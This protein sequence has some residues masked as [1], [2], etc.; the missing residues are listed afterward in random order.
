MRLDHYWMQQAVLQVGGQIKRSDGISVMLVGQGRISFPY[1]LPSDGPGIG[2]FQC[3]SPRYT[4]EIHH[5]EVMYTAGDPEAPIV[6]IGAGLFPFKYNPD[7]RDFGDYLLRI[8]PYPQLLQ[9]HFDSPYLR[10]LGLHVSSDFFPLLPEDVLTLHQD[11]LLSSE[12]NL[13]PLKDFSLA[14]LFATTIFKF[15]DVGAGIMGDRMFSVDDILDKPTAANN[16]NRFTFGGLKIMLRL[17]LDFK[18]FLPSKDLWGTNDWRF[19]S[20]ACLNG[21]KD[22]PITDTNNA[23]YPGY[24]DR[25]KRIPVLL[26]CNVPTCGLL[27]VLSIEGEWWGNNFANSYWGVFNVGYAMPPNPYKY[28]GS[29]RMDPYG[30]PWHWSVYAKKTVINNVKVTAQAAR[31]HTFIETSQS[32]LSNGDPQEAMDGLG[33]WAW[34]FK[35]EF[36]F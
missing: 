35:I 27:D 33:N 16:P 6:N 20:E 8:S 9:T 23:L 1:A 17:A 18:R 7:A 30:G 12:I 19:Y 2:G 11:L 31:D 28:P 29:N 4:W 5:A 36:G 15:A 24:N 21:W 14:Y 34:M 32:G 10:L 22:Y 13:W 3:Y 25:T 26:G